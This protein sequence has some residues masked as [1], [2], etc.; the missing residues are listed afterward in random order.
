MKTSLD[1]WNCLDCG[2]IRDPPNTMALLPE[3]VSMEKPSDGG[4]TLPVVTGTVQLPTKQ[5][6]T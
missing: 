3:R 5:I 1:P 4:N 6:T 2:L